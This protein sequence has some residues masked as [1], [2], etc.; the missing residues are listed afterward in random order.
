MAAAARYGA[1]RRQ[2]LAKCPE[3]ALPRTSSTGMPAI[4]G[5]IVAGRGTTAHEQ[6]WSRN[7]DRVPLR[8]PR[9]YKPPLIANTPRS[10]VVFSRVLCSKRA[11]LRFAFHGSAFVTADMW[12]F[13]NRDGRHDAI[14]NS[15][16]SCPAKQPG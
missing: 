16:C 12:I 15:R 13:C 5:E 11:N 8:A 14:R 9:R 7:S 1:P 6:G 4:F 3:H 2:M 10:A